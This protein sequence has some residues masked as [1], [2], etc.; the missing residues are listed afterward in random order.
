MRENSVIGAVQS[1][2]TLERYGELAERQIIP[3][4]GA[5][6][7]QHLKPEH[8]QQWHGTLIGEGL[9]PRTVGHAHRVLQ[10]VLQCSVKNGTAAR[11]V[12][13]VHK[14]PKV[15]QT[16]IEILTADQ[17]TDVRTK[18]EGHALYPIASLALATGMRRGELLALQWGDVDL[19]SGT[20]RVERSLE[21]TKVGG[22]RLKSPKT[23]RGR[24][25]ASSARPHD[26]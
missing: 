2:K 3:H 20:L 4:L 14:P 21:E 16:E 26:R 17:I 25:P 22:L 15:E 18:L 11:N 6:K 13:A 5:H 8:V 12:A 7:L 19:D 24:E 23:K 10:L 1:P 9:S